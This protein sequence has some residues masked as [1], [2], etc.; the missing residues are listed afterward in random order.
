MSHAEQLHAD[1]LR[2]DALRWILA[3]ADHHRLPVPARIETYQASTG[4]R[5]V[6]HLDDDQG[7]AV[8]RWADT[9]NLPTQD[10]LR[11]HSTRESW[12]AVSAAGP[13]PEIVF[14]G[15]TTISIESYCDFTTTTATT[16][17]A[18]LAVAA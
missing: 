7:D 4:W 5:L 2:A 18:T 6:L 1:Q 15:W 13:A 16:T 11:V 10:D 3:I 8:H 17:T 9:L 12:T 14:A